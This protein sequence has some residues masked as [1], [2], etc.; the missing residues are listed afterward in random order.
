MEAYLFA[1]Y[2]EK[3][4]PDGEQVYFSI[5]KDGMKWD[6]I[7]NG[8]PVIWSSSGEG[9]VRDISIIRAKTGRYYIFAAD[10]C[11]ANTFTQKYNR[12]WRGVSKYGSKYLVMWESDDLVHWSEQKMLDLGEESFGCMWSPGV[13]YDGEQGDHILYWLSSSERDGFVNKA[14]YYSRTPDFK[15]FTYPRLMY[16]R[17]GSSLNRA[18]ICEY[19]K[20]YYRFLSEENPGGVTLEVADAPTGKY[21]RIEAFDQ[22]ISKLDSPDRYKDPVVYRLKDGKWCL[23]LT[24]YHHG[25]AGGYIKLLSEDITAGKFKRLERELRFPYSFKNGSVIP[26]TLK[27]YERLKNFTEW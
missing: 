5:S 21:E 11:L 10:L 8:N 15:E 2:R 19:Q 4:T 18:V 17:N 13:V 6:K 26:I 16:R 9:G 20:R 25:V 24:F 12:D 1:H 7:N 27:E 23:L 14:L 22:L 3:P